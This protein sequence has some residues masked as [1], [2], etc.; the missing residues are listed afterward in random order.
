M[1]KLMI[2]ITVVVLAFTVIIVSFLPRWISPHSDYTYILHER[3][4]LNTEID[5]NITSETRNSHYEQLE[6]IAALCKP[7][8]KELEKDFRLEY[9]FVTPIFLETSYSDIWVP[10]NASRLFILVKKVNESLFEVTFTLSVKGEV[11]ELKNHSRTLLSLNRS[12]S[13]YYIQREGYY[14]SNGTSLGIVFP[15]FE[16]KNIV[17]SFLYARLGELPGVHYELKNVVLKRVERV[18]VDFQDEK[19]VSFTENGAV[20][21]SL[22]NETLRARLENYLA[23]AYRET[24]PLRRLTSCPFMYILEKYQSDEPPLL[25]SMNLPTGI[26]TFIYMNGCPRVQQ[27][28][29]VAWNNIVRDYYLHSPLA[30]LLGIR[31]LDYAIQLKSIYHG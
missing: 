5:T 12:I 8:L 25:V 3:N 15:L 26:P 27:E 9:V 13:T 16:S 4:Q 24:E 2:L 7:V 22:R 1:R 29:R 28:T 17:M 14:L 31:S 18:I 6:S 10:A 21:L 20:T 23:S 19:I 11:V 30:C